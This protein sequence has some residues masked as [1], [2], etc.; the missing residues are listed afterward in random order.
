MSDH[1]EKVPCSGCKRMIRQKKEAVSKYHF[2]MHSQCLRCNVEYAFHVKALI[3]PENVKDA[4]QFK[5]RL[6]E[7]EEEQ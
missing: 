2:I 4:E 3:H 7:L 5:K 6:A 1:R